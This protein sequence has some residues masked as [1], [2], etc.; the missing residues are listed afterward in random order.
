MPGARAFFVGAGG[1]PPGHVGISLGNGQMVNAAGTQWGTIISGTGG[2]MGFGIPPAGFDGG[3]W[4][5][6]GWTAAYNGTG[7]PEMVLPGGRGGYGNNYT[8][9]QNIPPTV[10]KAEVGRA[11]VECIREYEQRSGTAWRTRGRPG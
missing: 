10:N 8:I 1:A 7:R 3:G 9:I 2:N 11:T 6:P 5:R 4:L